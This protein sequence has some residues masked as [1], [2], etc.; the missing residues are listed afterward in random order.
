MNDPKVARWESMIRRI[1][2]D[3]EKLQSA[4]GILNHVWVGNPD[5]DNAIIQSIKLIGGEI[6]LLQRKRI[7]AEWYRDNPRM[8][9]PRRPT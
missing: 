9:P 4:L 7:E 8:P 6:A 3:V 5:P 2:A 1:D